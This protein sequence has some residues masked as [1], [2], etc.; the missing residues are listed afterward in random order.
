MLLLSEESLGLWEGP[1]EH[2]VGGC[3]V[4]GIPESSCSE[5][6]SEGGAGIPA[7]LLWDRNSCKRHHPNTLLASVCCT[8][9][10]AELELCPIC[11]FSYLCMK[12]E[13][14]GK[15]ERQEKSVSLCQT[16]EEVPSGPCRVQEGLVLN[17]L[18]RSCRLYSLLK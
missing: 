1:W 7:Q 14:E 5:G 11:S 9:P 17:S 10:G 6:A 2:P 12:W 16:K 3:G 18:S 4:L 13:E 15:G 8:L